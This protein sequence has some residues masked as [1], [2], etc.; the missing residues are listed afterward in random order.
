MSLLKKLFH[1]NIK[2]ILIFLT[3]FFVLCISIIQLKYDVLNK[4]SHIGNNPKHAFEGLY[5]IF[6]KE[7]F[8]NTIS[9]IINKFT[10]DIRLGVKYTLKDKDKY[11]PIESAK[12]R[13]SLPLSKII[14][15][16]PIAHL[17]K[18]ITANDNSKNWHRSYGSNSSTQYSSLKQINKKNVKNLQIAWNYKSAEEPKFKLPVETN[19]IIAEGRIFVP[20]VDNHLLSINAKTGEEI[21]KIKLPF[22]VAR[23]GLVWEKNVDFSKSRLFV[24]TSKGVFAINAESGEILKEFGNQGQVGNQLSLI[25]PIITKNSIIIAL[26]KPSVEAYDKKSGKLIWSTS[27]LQKVKNGIFTGSVP[28]GG[29]SYD[30]NRERIYVV[31]G[32]PRPEVVGTNRPG[33]N[34]HSNSL[35]SINSK[36]GNI[37]WEFQEVRHGLWDFDIASPP[38]LASITKDSKKID[39]VAAV[40]KIGNT[41]L[42]DRDYGKP[43]HDAEFRRAPTS[44]IPGEQTH[45]YQPD[46][47]LPEMF[48]KNVFEKNDV[49]NTSIEQEKNILLKIRNSKFGFFEPPILGGKITFFGV[50]GGAQWTGASFNPENSTIFVPSTQIPWQIFVNYTDLK[51]SD[52]EVASIKG[53]E[54]YQLSCA[55]C[56]G[57]KREG[58]FN[59]SDRSPSLVGITFLRDS[60]ALTSI[61]SYQK[62]HKGI[63][64]KENI[65]KINKDN[66]KVLYK[67]FSTIDNTIDKEGNFGINGFWK[68]LTDNKNCPGSKPPWL[69]LTAI[70]LVTGKIVWRQ[71]DPI[72]N[73]FNADKTCKNIPA[74]GFSMTTAGKIVFSIFDNRVKVFDIENGDLLW[75]WELDA[76]LSAPPST[77]AIDGIQYIIFVSS[78]KNNNITAFKLN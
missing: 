56:H 43:I 36:N 64:F 60:N 41:I 37:D 48:I 19:P 13:A 61:E 65:N 67:Y 50:G 62:M 63:S 44:K 72:K 20:T 6:R 55:S 9:I 71:N 17:K 58:K 12:K 35:V 52:R 68:S 21:W 32:N 26:I 78:K 27:L 59:R 66:L 1:I 74:Y 53:D 14:K 8:V 34:K 69:S 7:G 3:I 16:T 25:A 4:V 22:M 40:T 23:R 57:K 42:L 31:T 70:N 51:S 38:I 30:P 5:Q 29:M 11:P 75:S 77:Y 2:K 33:P 49:T 28:W 73:Y 18:S 24:P 76:A 54:I 39:I 10:Y 47:K 46:F 45:P 15:K